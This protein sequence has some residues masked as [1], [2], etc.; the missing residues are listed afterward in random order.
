MAAR[1]PRRTALWVL[2]FAAALGCAGRTRPGTAVP[3]PAT[4]DTGTVDIS[5]PTL[6]GFFPRL[7]RARMADSGFAGRLREFQ[8]GLAHLRPGF[9]RA[10]VAVFEQYTDTL[11]VREPGR[12]LQIYVPPGEDGMGYYLAAPGRDP[13]I[14]PGFRSERELQEAVWRYF[15][16][17]GVRRASR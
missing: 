16:E 17:H 5:G 7:T 4:A 6:I 8:A 13:D 15:H 11:A 10:G 12:G 14:I 2:L 9:E 3:L 1:R